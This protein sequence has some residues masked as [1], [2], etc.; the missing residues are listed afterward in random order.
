MSHEHDMIAALLD[1]TTKYA[2]TNDEPAGGDC[3]RLIAGAEAYLRTVSSPSVPPQAVIPRFALM[4]SGSNPLRYQAE[5]VRTGDAGIYQ[6]V[7]ISVFDREDICVADTLV[8]LTEAGEIRVLITADGDGD[9]E[10]QIAI[11]PTRGA[12]NA[13][14]GWEG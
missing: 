2:E 3:R 6:E 1:Y 7:R 14:E 10:H 13:I 12:A 4:H 11:F 9:N 8:G 5:A